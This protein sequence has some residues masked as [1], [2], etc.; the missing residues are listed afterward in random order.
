MFVAY[1]RK[2]YRM[3]NKL[4]CWLACQGEFVTGRLPFSIS[5]WARKTPVHPH[6]C[7]IS[8]LVCSWDSPNITIGCHH[9]Q[10]G[11]DYLCGVVFKMALVKLAKLCFKPITRLLG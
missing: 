3:F 10:I 4:L 1:P 7:I 6:E 11:M 9:H 5:P 2:H 8:I